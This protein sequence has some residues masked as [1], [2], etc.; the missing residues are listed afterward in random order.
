MEVQN[1]NKRVLSMAEDIMSIRPTIGLPMAVNMSNFLMANIATQ[2][3]VFLDIGAG[4]SPTPCNLYSLTLADSGSGKNSGLNLLINF[5]FKDAFD[6]IGKVVFPKFRDKAMEKLEA[7]GS[8]RKLHTWNKWMADSTYSGFLAYCETYHLAGFGSINLFIDEISNAI[9]SKADLFEMTLGIYDNGD[10][11]A[12][13]KRSDTESM[14][15]TGMPV[16][17]YSQGNVEKLLNG[18]NIETIFM[19]YLGEGGSRRTIFVNDDSKPAVRSAEEIMHEMIKSKEILNS[20]TKEREYIKSLINKDNLNKVLTMTDEALMEYC[21]IASE[22]ERIVANNK[23]LP[24]A[25][26]SDLLNRNFKT[27]KL[28]GVYAFFDKSDV[29]TKEH[30]IQAKEVVLES[31]KAL[32]KLVKIRPLH[33]RLLDAMIDEEKACTGQHLLS[34]PFIPSTWTKKIQEVIDLA[35]E[36][37][38]ERGYIW[39]EKVTKG[40]VY[41]RVKKKSKKDEDEFEEINKKEKE[42]V[43]KLSEEK[44]KLLEALYS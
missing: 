28:A 32:S 22:G 25:E 11:L 38:S 4:F 12:T 33:E 30:M 14:D 3:R 7:E 5:W 39:S 21:M 20:R 16:N 31:S 18:D 40:V 9:V 35:K 27:A 43:N 41:Y 1:L 37:G 29:V 13:A 42:E 2:C 26:I 10:A 8:E 36:L 19:R 15:I 44:R 23:G 24:Q 34:Y 17:L 6:Y